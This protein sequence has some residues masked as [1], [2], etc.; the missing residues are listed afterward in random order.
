MSTVEL[1]GS[2]P[3]Q[4]APNTLDQAVIKRES[5]KNEKQVLK[6][7]KQKYEKSFVFAQ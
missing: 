5:N 3:C 4:D 6:D 1:W 7:S 2:L